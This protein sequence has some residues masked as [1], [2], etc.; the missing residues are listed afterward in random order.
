MEPPFFYLVLQKKALPV[1]GDLFF[2]KIVILPP[3]KKIGHFTSKSE[4]QVF[5]ILIIKL[6]PRPGLEF[7]TNR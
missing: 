7:D 6:S 3:K 5:M 1:S 2:P 4:M